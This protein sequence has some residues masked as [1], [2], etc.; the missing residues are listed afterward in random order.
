MADIGLFALVLWF[1]VD[2][3]VL[4]SFGCFCRGTVTLAAIVMLMKDTLACDSQKGG[5]IT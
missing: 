1:A 2:V 4:V 3:M 5:L